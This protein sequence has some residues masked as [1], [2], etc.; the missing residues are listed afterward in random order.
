MPRVG[1][2]LMAEDPEE[3]NRLLARAVKELTGG[4]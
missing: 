4:R 3:F 1:H 2:F